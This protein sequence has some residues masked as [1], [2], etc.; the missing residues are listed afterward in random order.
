VILFFLP[1]FFLIYY[2]P[3]VFDIELY[4]SSILSTALVLIYIFYRALQNQTSFIY[5]LFFTVPNI[6]LLISALTLDFGW[7]MPEIQDFSYPSNSTFYLSILT[8]IF[9]MSYEFSFCSKRQY[10]NLNLF[11]LIYRN[12]RTSKIIFIL[13]SINVFF[14]FFI[15]INGSPMLSFVQRFDYWQS[16]WLG[17]FFSKVF[18][19]TSFC[20]FFYGYMY[21]ENPRAFIF[22]AIFLL[23]LSIFFANK[24]SWFLLFIIS[25]LGGYILVKNLSFKDYI[26]LI[27]LSFILLLPIISFSYLNLHDIGDLSVLDM[28]FLRFFI[29]QG[30]LWWSIFHLQASID[31]YS[32]LF[33]NDGLYGIWL[34]MD[35]V[36]PSL[37][38]DQYFERRIPLTMGYPVVLYTS[39]GFVASILF[40][41]ALGHLYGALM[42]SIRLVLYKLLYI[43]FFIYTALLSMYLWILTLGALNILFNPLFIFLNFI[44]ILDRYI[45]NYSSFH[46]KNV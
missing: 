1:I 19:L 6:W 46:V 17:S 13:L 26:K 44:M 14:L 43:R 29:M 8:L 41:A 37:A 38:F 12:K 25:F 45:L 39:L 35:N 23:L 34:L 21:R 31:F 36:M 28:V 4:V 30:Q 2:I 11:N 18:Y 20:G 10:L 32:L 7:Y 33:G 9:Y 27:A 3:F 42:S 22:N 40:V 24:F 16:V 15:L 5:S